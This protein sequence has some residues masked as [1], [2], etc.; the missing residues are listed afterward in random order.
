MGKI[1]KI[2]LNK[3][4]KSPKRYIEPH[5]CVCVC[6]CACVC[7]NAHK[8]GKEGLGDFWKHIQDTRRKGDGTRSER[9]EVAWSPFCTV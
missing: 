2:L 7:V 4:E 5:L 9:V 6:L 3:G 1:M 8:P